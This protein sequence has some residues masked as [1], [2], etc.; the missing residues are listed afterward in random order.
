[1]NESFDGAVKLGGNGTAFVSITAP[2]NNIVNEAHAP[3][4]NVGT[5]AEM[6]A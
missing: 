1:M 3:T 6:N 5:V 2:T 4:I